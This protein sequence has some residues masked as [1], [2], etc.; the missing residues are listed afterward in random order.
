[1]AGLF[2]FRPS[3]DAGRA[4]VTVDLEARSPVRVSPL[5]F[6][7]FCEHLGSNI[8]GGMEAQVLRNPTFGAWPRACPLNLNAVQP[9]KP[10]AVTTH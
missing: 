6:G 3:E 9:Y 5:L 10:E 7:K 8:Y 2:S 4:R 1:M